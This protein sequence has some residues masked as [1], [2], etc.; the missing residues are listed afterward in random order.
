MPYGRKWAIAH[1]RSK[2]EGQWGKK[3]NFLRGVTDP[4]LMAVSSS[5]NETTR[6]LTLTHPKHGSIEIRPNS[7]SG[8][9]QLSDWLRGLWS[10]DLPKP[11][12]I[13]ASDDAHMTD[14]PDPWIS[15]NSISSLKSLSQRSGRDLSK[16]RF[17][18][19]IWVEGLSPWEEFNWV[20]KTVTIGPV[21]L[22]VRETITRC[23]ATMANPETGQRD[24]DTLEIL[25]ELGHQDFGVYAEVIEGGT[26][27]LGDVV[28]APA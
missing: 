22:S 27:A 16:H 13:Y 20:G 23:K 6:L 3:A 25:D 17:R 21:S 12:G 19:N 7:A 28:I 5:F 8:S 24:V 11:T 14:V 18:G 2:L 4:A 1:E 10:G 15:I 9:E 26:I